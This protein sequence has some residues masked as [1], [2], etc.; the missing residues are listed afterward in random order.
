L[1]SLQLDFEEYFGAQVQSQQ[2]AARFFGQISQLCFIFYRLDLQYYK[3]A[4]LWTWLTI[5]IEQ[6]YHNL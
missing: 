2:R 6:N 4:S 1:Q 5:I 3:H